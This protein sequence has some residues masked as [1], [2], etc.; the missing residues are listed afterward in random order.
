[1]GHIVPEQLK[2]PAVHTDEHKPVFVWQVWYWQ[3]HHRGGG[4]LHSREMYPAGPQT[5]RDEVSSNGFQRLIFRSMI[6]LNELVAV[7]KIQVEQDYYWR[8]N[9]NNKTV[10]C[11]HPL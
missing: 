5:P 4:G 10:Y 1:M 11:R 8:R 7:S 9:I 6:E 2:S 3:V